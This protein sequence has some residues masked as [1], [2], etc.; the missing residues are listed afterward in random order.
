MP[1][2]EY[3]QILPFQLLD[4]D[5]GYPVV[6]AV[7]SQHPYSIDVYA[8]CY[9]SHDCVL[10]GVLGLDVMVELGLHLGRRAFPAYGRVIL[11]AETLVYQSI[12][13]WCAE[14]GSL[15]KEGR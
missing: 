7:S 2:I 1:L 10:Q 5:G 3:F 15:K 4:H 12:S 8:N 13:S 9:H 11:T 6:R 14:E